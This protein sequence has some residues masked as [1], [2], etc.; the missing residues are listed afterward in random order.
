[1]KKEILAYTAGLFDG[2]GSINIGVKKPSDKNWRR[3][4]S[5]F[6]RIHITNTDKEIIDWLKIIFGG[7]ITND[8][9][10][11]CRK[12]K[13]RKIAWA[14]VITNIQAKDFLKKIYSYLKIKQ[15]QAEIA[16]NFQ[17]SKKD[18][19]RKGI[20]I[21][22]E[23]IHREECRRKIMQLNHGKEAI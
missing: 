1:M 6:L 16:I 3:V 21:Q 10:C 5:H 19:R 13:E 15:K 18:L 17:E 4:N 20:H 12:G 2:E 22:M 14:W 11:F 9:N 23:I 7:F 8:S